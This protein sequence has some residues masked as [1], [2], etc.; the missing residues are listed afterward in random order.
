MIEKKVTCKDRMAVMADDI[1]HLKEL[2]HNIVLS[3]ASILMELHDL[4]DR[5]EG[6]IDDYE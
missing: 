3:Q 2:L 4:R 1:S 6:E 5:L